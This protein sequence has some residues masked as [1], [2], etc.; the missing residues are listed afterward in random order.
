MEQESPARKQLVRDIK[1][2]ALRRMED[3]AR[4]LEDYNEVNKKWNQRDRSLCRNM[5]RWEIGRPNAEMLHWDKANESADAGG[6]LREELDTVIPRPLDHAWWRQLMRGDFLDAIHDCPYELHELTASRMISG[7]LQTLN[8][9]QLEV[10]YYRV[11]RQETPQRVAMRRKQSDRNIL[12][13]YA[14]LIEGL[15][16][17]LY[18]R[19]ASRL[20][21][22]SQLTHSQITFMEDYG[23]GRL[24]TGKP[25]T[26]KQK[27]EREKTVLDEKNGR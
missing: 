22:G 15:R 9:N 1:R 23:E 5:R 25:K 16:K 24:K 11:I 27:K 19:L 18:A 6:S 4:T 12:K 21:E 10:M 7:I 8:E 14:T 13:V 3:G 20:A 2:E 17:K 26:D